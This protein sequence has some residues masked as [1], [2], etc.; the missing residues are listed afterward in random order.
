MRL[1]EPKFKIIEQ[2][3]GYTGMLK[4][5]E[6]AGR[7]CYKS[8]ATGTDEG[9]YKFVKR[10]IDSG[11][12]SVLE[13]GT[14][15]LKMPIDNMWYTRFDVNPYSRVKI[16][17]SDNTLCITTNFRVLVENQ[18]DYLIEDYMTEP[19]DV[20][21]ERI[22]VK[23]FTQIAISREFNRHR[24]NS[25]SESSTRYC[26]FSK[27]KFGNEIAINKPAFIT[28]EGHRYLGFMDYIEKIQSGSDDMDAIDW[29]L[30]ANTAC[31]AAYMKLTGFGWSA[32]QAR[33]ILPLD[34]NTEL[35]HTAFVSDWERFIKQRADGIT[36]A[37]HIDAY[38]L[39]APLKELFK[40]M[41]LISS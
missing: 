29:W 40:S 28:M 11:H 41:N 3:P 32:Q 15:Y 38:V 18:W 27:D 30:F 25:P 23:F 34:T 13:H 16:D 4:Q 5:I 12:M 35:V 33:T 36:G 21:E 20:H 19:T 37:P 1:L 14:V 8:E 6:I 39:A 10:M 9:A 24:V 17:H 7:T 26:N 31:E 2:A 22:T